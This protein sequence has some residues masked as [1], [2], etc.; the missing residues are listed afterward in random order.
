MNPRAVLASVPRDS[1]STPRSVSAM[2]HPSAATTMYPHLS[3]TSSMSPRIS[4]RWPKKP[5]PNCIT[6]TGGEPAGRAA[7]RA[8]MSTVKGTS[9][10]PSATT[11]PAAS[12]FTREKGSG[13][14]TPGFRRRAPRAILSPHRRMEHPHAGRAAPGGRRPGRPDPPPPRPSPP[15]PQ[16]TPVSAPAVAA[17]ARGPGLGGVVGA[18]SALSGPGRRCRAGAA[19][20]G[21]R[22]VVGLGRRGRAG[23]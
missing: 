20:P 4:V 23:A 9:T 3:A 17:W 19:W 13:E 11:S 10:V 2:P 8:G 1:A 18:R 14:P 21:R 6:R 5:C 22:G 12:W 16:S 15:G 7:T